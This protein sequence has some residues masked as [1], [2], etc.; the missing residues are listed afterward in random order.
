V[1]A[2]ST[3]RRDAYRA[4]FRYESGREPLGAD[5]RPAGSTHPHAARR[6]EDTLYA[7]GGLAEQ[8]FVPEQEP[9]LYREDRNRWEPRAPLPVPR[10]ASGVGARERRWAILVGGWGGRRG[11]RPLIA[12]RDL[13]IRD[14]PLARGGADPDGRDVNS[15]DAAVAAVW[16]RDRRATARS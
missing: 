15:S 7:V 11:V 13:M 4:A 10:G 6:R 5:R 3:A 16:V 9:W 14:R 2:G 12:R 1:A 8:S